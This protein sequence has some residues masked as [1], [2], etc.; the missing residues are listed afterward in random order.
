M[1]LNN[2]ADYAY[3]N[4]SNVERVYTSRNPELY[5][6][7]WPVNNSNILFLNTAKAPFDDV[8]VRKAIAMAVD[9]ADLAA[10]A[11]AGTSVG[12]ANPSGII[13]A[14]QEEWLDASL[15]EADYSYDPEAAGAMLTEAGLHRPKRQPDRP[16]GQRAPHL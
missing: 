15:A 3:S 12:A 16:R 13:P 14:Q 8:A 5:D 10:K 2:E 7:W 6:Y 11:Y 1:L 4:I 9:K